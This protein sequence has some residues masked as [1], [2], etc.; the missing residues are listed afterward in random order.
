MCIV[1]G[2]ELTLFYNCNA[3]KALIPKISVQQSIGVFIQMQLMSFFSYTTHMRH[4]H[5]TTHLFEYHECM[6]PIAI[7]S[8]F[9]FYFA[10]VVVLCG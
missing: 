2:H 1:E 9:F 5:I 10:V 4:S 8:L 7:F 6:V 3:N